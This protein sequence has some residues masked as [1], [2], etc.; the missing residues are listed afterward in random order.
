MKLLANSSYGYQIRDLCRHTVTNYLSDEKTDAALIAKLL[1]KLDHVNNSWY[2]VELAKAQIEHQE[3]M[4][5]GL[6]ILQFPKLRMLELYYNFV[7][8]YCDVNGDLEMDIDALYLALAVNELQDCIRP[9][10]K[11]E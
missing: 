2:E 10:M 11:S 5:V 7:T 8:K 1:K 6:F 9:E 3:P 4:I